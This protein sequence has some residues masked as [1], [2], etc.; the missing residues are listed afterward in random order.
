MFKKLLFFIP[1]AAIG[2]IL[3]TALFT[4]DEATGMVFTALGIFI[5]GSITTMLGK[6]LFLKSGIEAEKSGGFISFL[7]RFLIIAIVIVAA[8]LLL[9][10]SGILP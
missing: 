1:G 5:G 2:Y 4:I 3:S 10:K 7:I 9:A 6:M 8:I